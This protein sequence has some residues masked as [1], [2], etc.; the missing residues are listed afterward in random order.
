[1]PGR[2]YFVKQLENGRF[3]LTKPDANTRGS[4]DECERFYVNPSR[5]LSLVFAS[6]FVSTGSI[7]KFLNVI[8]WFPGN[9]DMK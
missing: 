5:K 7:F 8:V 4:L 9:L 1:M 3:V 6:G 2:L